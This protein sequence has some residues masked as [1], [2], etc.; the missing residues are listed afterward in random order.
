VK[1]IPREF[2]DRGARVFLS[3]RI[4]QLNPF[5]H[6]DKKGP[7]AFRVD[8]FP[9]ALECFGPS[10]GKLPLNRLATPPRNGVACRPDYLLLDENID[11]TRRREFAGQPS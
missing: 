4:P 7:A 6:I 11:F 2:F 10:C 1:H 5:Q 3:T 9:G 8:G